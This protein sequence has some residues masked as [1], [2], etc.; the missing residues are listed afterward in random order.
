M[1]CRGE[2]QLNQQRNHCSLIVAI[3]ENGVIGF[4]NK[5]PW[6]LPADLLYFKKL[7]LN[8]TVIMG[9]R[10]Y[11]SI[12]KPL[13]NRK[14]VIVTRQ[15]NFMVQGCEVVHSLE[16]ALEKYKNDEVMIIGG[17]SLYKESLPYVNRMYLTFVKANVKGDTYFPEFD[18][19]DWQEISRQD[20]EPDV[21]NPYA[22]S[23][24]VYERK[25]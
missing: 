9:R 17:A 12:G 24:V 23:F 11:E 14:N 5:L 25:I 15:K 22:Y 19:K 7:T 16:D 10:T 6:H 20:H 4:E 13:P 2:I 18:S 1:Q 3:A 21:K 8:K